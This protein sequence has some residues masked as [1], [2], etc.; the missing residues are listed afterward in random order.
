MVLLDKLLCFGGFLKV[1]VKPMGDYST[2]CYILEFDNFEIIIDTGVNSL[3]WIEKNVKNPRAILLTHAHFDHMWDCYKVAKRYNIPIYLNKRDEVLL[4]NDVFSRG[5]EKY[6][7]DLVYLLD[8]N[9]LFKIDE[10][11]IRF[12]HFPGHSEGSSVIEIE[13]S[14]FVGDLIFQGSIGRFD[15]PYSDKEKMRDSLIKALSLKESYPIYS[16]HGENTTLKEEKNSLKR[17]IETW[18]NY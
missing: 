13:K 12:H 18:K 8:D 16:G 14:Y 17:W 9:T 15:F 7:K 4:Q 2:N 5:I 1:K 6:Q 10:V 3:P 11:E